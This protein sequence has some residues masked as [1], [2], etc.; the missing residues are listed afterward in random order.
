M[1]RR[2][3]STS[4]GW[5]RG[6]RAA[7][8]AALTALL[9]LLGV[10][11][12]HAAGPAVLSIE[13]TPVDAVTGVTL[14]TAGSGQ[15]NNRLAYRIGYSCSVAECTGAVVALPA[16]E[17]DPTYGQ[18]RLHRYVTWTPPAGGGATIANNVT[19]GTTVQL[20]NVAAGTS[21]TFLV[22]YERDIDSSAPGL[23]PGSYFPN[24]YQIQRS[25]T[26]TS[27][28][29]TAAVTAT[30]PAVT[31][32]TGVAAPA[33]T[34]SGATTTRP[35]TDM[36][37]SIG[38]SDGCM[39]HR[40]SGRWTSNGSLVC[41]E[42]Y[43]VV[44]RLPA[45]AVFVSETG[46][47]VYDSVTHTVTWT[48][49]G[50]TAAGGWGAPATGGWTFGYGYNPRTVTVRYPASAFPEGAGGADFV[51]PV[52]NNVDVSVTYLDD[53]ATV[54]TATNTFSHDVVRVEP[55][56]RSDQT[57]IG[58][59]DQI[60]SGTR[61]VDV[62]PDTTGLTCPA[63]G[64]D[65]WNR[66]CTPGQPV[67]AFATR[68]DRSWTI[69][70]ANRG[71][72]AGVAT[73]VDNDLGNSSVRVRR[74]T[75]TGGTGSPTIDWTI[76]DGTATT[77]GTTTATTYT[78]PTG[79]WL[80]AATVTSGSL[81]GPN[82]LP[83]QNASTVFRVVFGY[84]VPVGSQL[85]TWNNSATA[86]M[87]YPGQPQITPIQV[88]SSGA[89]TFRDTPKV[90]AP[91]IPPAFGAT[92][93]GTPVVEGGGQVVPGGKVTF[94]V[95]GSTANIPAAR[96]VSPQYV[97]I[98]PAGWAVV[99][100]SATFDPATI[101]AG[102]T[103]TYKTVTVAGVS[104]QA[105]IASW[106][107]GATFGKNGNWPTMNVVASP[108]FA[109]AAG[110]NSTATTWAGDSRNVYDPTAT[111]WI[112]KVVDATDVDGDGNTSEAFASVG[113]VAVQV[114]GTSRLDVVKE[115]CV[116]D[117][118]GACTWVSNPDIVVGVDPDATDIAYRVTLRNGGNTTLAGVVGYDVL[119]W[120]GDA[121]GST[122]AE[123]LSSVTSASS[124]LTLTY[125]SSTNPC[126]TEVL[127]TN[128]GCATGW[129]AAASG[130]NA[131]R[132]ELAG[133]LAPGASASFEFSATVVPGAPAD[134]I[135]C[136]SVAVD[137]SS[138]LP[139]EPR[140]V[141]AT[142]QE[143]DLSI[144]VPDRLPLQAGRPGTVPFTVTNLGGSVAAPATVEIEVPAGIRITSLTPAGWLCEAASSEPDGSVLGPVTL[145]CDAVD[146]T[147]T[148]R[149]LALGV[150]DALDLP[151]VIPDASLVGD[152]TCFPAVVSG[153]MSDPV[154]SNNDDS[155][156][157]AV[158]E[159]DAL[160]SITK[161]DGLTEA[162]IGDTLTYTLDVSNLL[163]GESLGA[164]TVTDVLPDGVTFLA[165]SSGGT[166]SDQGA[167]DADGFQPGGTVTW[168]LASLAPAG[169]P[170]ADGETP[171]GAAGSTSSVTVTV[172]VLQSAE[173]LDE[174][175][176]D[177]TAAA[178]D[179]ASPD[180]LLEDADGDTDALVHTPAI[181]IVKSAD[182]T[183]YDAVG[184]TIS[185]GFRVTNSGDVTLTGV[186][187]IEEAFTGS[188]TLPVVSCAVTTL[189]PGAFVDCTASYEIE[190]GDL[191][192]GTLV[193]AASATGT[194]P[195]G[196]T[197]PASGTSTVTV[198][199]VRTSTLGLVKTATP[200][201]ADAAGDTISYSFAVTNTG[202]V[203][204]S[205]A[206]IVE[207]AFTGDPGE[208]TA[209]TC[210]T[211]A[212]AP[213]ATVTCTATYELTQAD[214]DAGTVS[215]TAT[216]TASAPTGVT[217]PVSA[218]STAT[219]TIAPDASLAIVKS[220]S[221]GTLIVGQTV[222]YSFV[223][224]NTGNV[225]LA[226]VD[227]TETAFTGSGTMSAIGCDAA[228]TS[229]APDA[230]TVCSATYL[231]TQDDVDAATLGNTAVA[232]GTSP[233][234][235][236]SSDP[237]TVTLP[238]A[239]A[240]AVGIVKTADV[241]G[242]SAADEDIEYRFRVTNT[243]NVTMT[244]V[245]VIDEDFSGAGALGAIS[246]PLDTLL[247]GQFTV[248]TADYTVTQDDIDAGGLENTASAEA[249]AP[250]ATLPTASTDSSLVLPFIG[251]MEL[252]L[253][254][255]GTGVDTNRDGRVTD[256][257]R[258]QWRFTVTNTGAATLSSLVVD[259]PTAGTVTCDVV[260]LAPGDSTACAAPDHAIGNAD[261]S[262]GR[263]V[264]VATA[265]AVGV[266]GAS[267]DSD[268]ATATV[269]V[270][271][272]PLADTGSETLRLL[273]PGLLLLLAGVA[274]AA[275]ATARRPAPRRRAA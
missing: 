203:T 84:D 172:R 191:N 90:T 190:Q 114:S 97:F 180:D 99:P 95:R 171:T 121:R 187:V 181:S 129:A 61:Y 75:T 43:T 247:P 113:S 4:R 245:E 161:D 251:T 186:N 261:V 195:A 118:G 227:V 239:Q 79:W 27:P 1:F 230:Q 213:A 55:F 57:K 262:A 122:F 73:V 205:D 159:A 115:I 98:A 64:R 117:A 137:S 236:V 259:D 275:V 162:S 78:A 264:N 67:P 109:V 156:C 120:V 85:F 38:M 174:L 103:Y 237:S 221:P 70:T 248:C 116:E 124:G 193:N 6:G 101:P 226:G 164:V 260:A 254:K 142:T 16:I 198:T 218:S 240:P 155:A 196:L 127:P 152:D 179:P 210:P 257:D 83:S 149:S 229:L 238:F 9:V 199:A 184:D 154:L 135:A 110:T 81:A 74:V 104:R 54:K 40:G 42:S 102:V 111:T 153:L 242:V 39:F 255:T 148:A 10:S 258:I 13:I 30:A 21:S 265:S 22:V 211:G 41:A 63:G 76:T 268:A 26:I 252:H 2:T 126:R 225:T 69:D 263:V 62:P 3:G 131:I 233:S 82:L 77:S 34:T 100:N 273:A 5:G 241:A 130:A 274:L 253:V 107:T 19:T 234:G 178:A 29:A 223:V 214:V 266:G 224:T 51:V 163:A 141:C 197:A 244:D 147:G 206:E 209:I 44:D 47:G 219:V 139:G 217:D 108:T 185:Y 215:N 256:G 183:T 204:V 106:P 37:Y 11:P 270:T 88:A 80:T 68:T 14:T 201:T 146:G 23:V 123:T 232:A 177:A 189:A 24:G 45:Q 160:L 192:R 173:T 207:G 71:N 158:V 169:V 235:A 182:V 208:L 15:N 87:T 17:T 20:G 36:T 176:N 140:A 53:A 50:A 188:G 166:V 105:V 46:G 96:D 86:T 269:V 138:T 119:P 25:A 125:S 151:A 157:F 28:N 250:S 150:P 267:V 60:V 194:P 93:V 7:I 170:D 222:T 65:D 246:C 128:P 72:V 33:I 134:A 112:G 94:A 56:G 228:A 143:A 175:V 136:N 202:N 12:A 58:N 18:F 231:I 212:I 167:P 132:A 32:Q 89:V 168:T 133:S 52:T 92:F 216:A 220:A 49:T 8:A 200:T 31:W 66:V 249:L 144:S 48:K 243:G 272:R 145:S 271:A 91:V 59:T 165:A 35:D